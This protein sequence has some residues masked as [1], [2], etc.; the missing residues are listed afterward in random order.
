MN[1]LP[2]K[3][4]YNFQLYTALPQKEWINAVA[5]TERTTVIVLQKAT[6]ENLT[7]LEKILG[8]V[9]Q[10]LKNDCLVIQEE[11]T[12]AF[13]DLQQAIPVQRL[14]VFGWTPA[15]LGLHLTIRP[16]QFV[17]FD[18]VELLFSPNLEAIAAN[19][20]KEKQQLWTPLQQLFLK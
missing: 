16:Y 17:T 13:K 15:D 11:E 5:N 8:A 7:L 6:A 10:D 19:V 12:I 1:S 20:H 4:F 9:K 3:D 18:G 14:L 2:N